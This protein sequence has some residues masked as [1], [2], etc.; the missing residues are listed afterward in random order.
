[1]LMFKLMGLSTLM[2]IA[3]ADVTLAQLTYVMTFSNG[4]VG[5]H[6]TQ[7]NQTNQTQT[8]FS[9]ASI[10]VV[11]F[12]SNQSSSQNSDPEKNGVYSEIAEDVTFINTERG[13]GVRETTVQTSQ[14]YDFAVYNFVYS[15]EFDY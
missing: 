9:G 4:A 11:N 12:E 10:D 14:E 15:V 8:V 5:H 3:S 7:T 2:L 6:Q 13:H 1:M